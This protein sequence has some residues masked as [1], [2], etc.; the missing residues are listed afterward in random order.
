MQ[1]P[2]KDFPVGL[3]EVANL[4]NYP[5]GT[6]YM[7]RARK[8][9]PDPDYLVGGRPAWWWHQTILPWAQATGRVGETSGASRSDDVA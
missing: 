4:L 3:K 2:S 6:A 8:V 7:W 5:I 1:K 9:L